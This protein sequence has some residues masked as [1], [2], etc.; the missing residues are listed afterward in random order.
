VNLN[1]RLEGL[2]QLQRLADRHAKLKAKERELRSVAEANE[3]GAC[4]VELFGD[5]ERVE[6]KNPDIIREALGLMGAKLGAFI[7][8]TESE[9]CAL[10][11]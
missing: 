2:E 3:R 5:G 1:D 11:V 7:L 4:T 10:N 6:V 8:D 9:I